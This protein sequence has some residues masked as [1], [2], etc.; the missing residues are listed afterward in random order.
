MD[1]QT[2][3]PSEAEDGRPHAGREKP[4]LFLIAS[5]IGAFLFLTPVQD[6]GV[7]KIPLAVLSDGA[8]EVFKGVLDEVVVGLLIASA[9]L[10]TL[11]KLGVGKG[12]GGGA[13]AELFDPEWPWFAM[14]WLGAVSI[15]M[16]YFK[17]GPE[18]LYSADVGGVVLGQL[19][20]VILVIF[21]FSAFLLPLLTEF[22]LMEFVGSVLQGPFQRLFRVP[23]RAAIDAVAS[24]LGSNTVGV[25][26]TLK[27]YEG[28]HYTAREASIV[29]T[30]FSVVST[31]FC[32]AVASVLNI[33]EL[34]VPYYLAVVAA[35][36][37]C[38][39]V[40]PR[41][42]PLS[43]KE[44]RYVDGRERED[45]PA[46]AEPAWKT[47]WT[48][49]CRKAG[50]APGAGALLR[51]ST[52]NVLDIWLGLLPSVVFIATTALSV[53]TQTPFFDVLAAP[54]I[55]GMNLIGME[56]AD[57]AGPSMLIGFADMFLPAILTAE[58]ESVFTRL[59]VGVVSVSQLIYM[60]E[61]GVLI[62]RSKIPLSFL[63]LTIVFLMRTIIVMP[64]AYVA[65]LIVVG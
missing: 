27:Q 55:W 43:L 42:P 40:M 50:A 35:S 16:I 32:Y 34:F 48:I 56:N 21:F 52:L 31:A 33:A 4:F 36:L 13:A 3:R 6:G 10:S 11:Y 8:T 23:G 30:N 64:I 26:I 59:F 37:V 57:V 47:G 51:K 25:L 54:I 29:A 60:S 62:M 49:A 41:I 44:D 45:L 19:A 22:G 17:L 53:A 46:A 18:W 63:E 65:A 1:I 7:W 39:V 15:V 14:R 24:W 12:D 28:G 2:E 20:P 9:A 58:A 61:L 38:A 5:L